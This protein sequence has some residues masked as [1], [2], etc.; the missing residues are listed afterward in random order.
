MTDVLSVKFPVEILKYV[1]ENLHHYH[2][3]DNMQNTF[4]QKT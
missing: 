1:R 2:N 3:Y 4:S